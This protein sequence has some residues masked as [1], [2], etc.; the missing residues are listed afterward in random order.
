MKNKREDIGSLGQAVLQ[1]K[2]EQIE[3]CRCGLDG[4]KKD[5]AW[6]AIHGLND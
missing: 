6:T 5:I 2:T 3:N 4:L 1:R